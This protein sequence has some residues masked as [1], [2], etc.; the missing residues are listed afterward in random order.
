MNIS[1]NSFAPFSNSNEL[2]FGSSQPATTASTAEK[3]E[4]AADYVGAEKKKKYEEMGTLLKEG[5]D[6]GTIS[7]SGA[8]DLWMESY[9]EA[10]TKGD[11]NKMA[12][13]VKTGI[14]SGAITKAEG[15]ELASDIQQQ[16]NRTGHGIVKK[17]LQKDLASE[18]YLGDDYVANGKTA[19]AVGFEKLFDGIGKMFG[20]IGKMF[21]LGG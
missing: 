9:N 20:S 1:T 5:V 11:G 12:N 6:N 18:E 16:A 3:E 2:S 8:R 10:Y 4:W 15:I 19:A 17:D 13:L 14:D 7:Q 21:G